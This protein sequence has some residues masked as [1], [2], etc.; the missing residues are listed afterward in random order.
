MTNAISFPFKRAG[1]NGRA[2][3]L[4]PPRIWKPAHLADFLGLSIHWV[5]KRTE[6]AAEDPIPRLQG[7]G[8]LRFDTH[9]PAFQAWMQRQ[10]GYAIDMSLDHE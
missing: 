9:A 4:P 5:Y 10:L 1:V 3:E 8:R 7:V 2:L 6:A